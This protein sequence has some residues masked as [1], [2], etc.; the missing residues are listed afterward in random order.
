MI[1][2]ATSQHG[3]IEVCWLHFQG[4]VMSS[5]FIYSLLYE[6]L[7]FYF[8]TN[9]KGGV[10]NIDFNILSINSKTKH[11]QVL[12]QVIRISFYLCWGHGLSV[13]LQLED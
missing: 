13:S 2:T 4:A 3:V 11:T 8:K 12:L 5:I 9:V 7:T 6:P 10:Y 1:Y